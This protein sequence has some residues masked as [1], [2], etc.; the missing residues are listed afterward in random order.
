MATNC[1]NERVF[2]PKNAPWLATFEKNLKEFPSGGND[3]DADLTAYAASLED[4]IS[5]AEVL[6]QL[7]GR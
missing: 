5:I 7:Q 3:E 4:Q 2:F 1:E 6:K